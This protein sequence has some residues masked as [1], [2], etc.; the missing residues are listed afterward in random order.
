[1]LQSQMST[2]SK[3]ILI[4]YYLFFFKKKEQYLNQ[5]NH[6]HSLFKTLNEY[7]SRY[8]KRLY[9]LGNL[10]MITVTVKH[11]RF[12]FFMSLSICKYNS[13]RYS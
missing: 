10:M 12:C 6:S 13:L 1:M 4:S 9:P 7:F 8:K 3:C 5:S 2:K 11:A